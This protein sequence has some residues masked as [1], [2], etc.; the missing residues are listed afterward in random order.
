MTLTANSRKQVN[1][2]PVPH[3]VLQDVINIYINLTMTCEVAYIIVVIN[4]SINITLAQP[5]SPCP[6]PQLEPLP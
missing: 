6:R 1:H 4:M 5:L 2:N 3:I